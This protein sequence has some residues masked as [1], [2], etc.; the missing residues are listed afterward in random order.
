MHWILICSLLFVVTCLVTWIIHRSLKEKL[1]RHASLISWKIPLFTSLLG[2]LV[3]IQLGF[4]LFFAQQYIT[5]RSERKELRKQIA[6]ELINT[7]ESLT[8]NSMQ[9]G[10]KTYSLSITYLQP[11]ALESGI[12]SGLFSDDE[13]QFMLFVNRKMHWHNQLVASFLSAYALKDVNPDFIDNIT[14]SLEATRKALITD[15]AHYDSIV[16]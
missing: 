16:E 2:T 9:I 13:L 5:D 1:T 7:K 6:A 10:N 14:R 4:I 11:L 8:P 3:S 12:R 15:I